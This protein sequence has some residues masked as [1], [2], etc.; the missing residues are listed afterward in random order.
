[1]KNVSQERL[2]VSERDAAPPTAPSI[3]RRL[4]LTRK[5]WFGLPL[6]AAVPLLTLFGLFGER[7]SV[8][9]T[10]SLTL[11]LTVTYPERFRYRQVQ[12]LEVTVRNRSAQVLDTVHLSL[13]TAYIT[14]F[15]S[16]RIEPPPQIAFVVDLTNV[17]P[18]ESR[19]VTAE[20]G[21]DRYGRHPGR[22]LAWTRAAQRAARG[23]QSA[24][25]VR[26]DS[27]AVQFQTMVFP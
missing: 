19:L 10:A 16:V 15:A 9:R 14:R 11:E 13:D 25:G 23:A 1:M 22:I 4:S 21:G 2:G 20:L 17:R 3:E 18:N 6:L 7:R 26:A 27:A 8:V 5:Q 24:D 12:L